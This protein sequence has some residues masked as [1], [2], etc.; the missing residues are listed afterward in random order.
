M[1]EP[2]AQPGR[3]CL[4]PRQI[5]SF[6]YAPPSHNKLFSKKNHCSETER[7]KLGDGVIINFAHHCEGLQVV[8]KVG[9][10]KNKV[11]NQ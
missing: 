8:H 4:K 6:Y 9:L 1:L 3:T 7:V 5:R 10:L 2:P 11:Y